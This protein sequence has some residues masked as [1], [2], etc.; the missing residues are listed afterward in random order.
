MASGYSSTIYFKNQNG[1]A[2]QYKVTIGVSEST[3][4]INI[5]NALT[6]TA[7]IQPNGSTWAGNA[8]TMEILW[9]GGV[10]GSTTLT[11][12][13]SG[14]SKTATAKFTVFHNGTT[15]KAS[16]TI[17]V[18]IHSGST[19]STAPAN[20][21]VSAGTATLTTINIT[22][23]PTSS[24]SISGITPT[25]VTAKATTAGS[26]SYIKKN[27][28]STLS[29]LITNYPD[30]PLTVLSD[31]SVWARI[32]NHDVRAGAV[33]WT[34][35]EALNTQQ[36][37]KYSRLHI[38]NDSLKDSSGKFEFFLRYPTN[39]LSAYNRWK[40]STAPQNTTI[41]RTTSGSAAPGYE[42]VNISW[43]GAYWGGLEYCS[44]GYTFL[45]GSTGHANWW[46][47][48]APYQAY[49]N[50]LPGPNPNICY[51]QTELWV[52]IPGT[53]GSTIAVTA[54]TAVTITGLQPET[55]YLFCS[56]TTN[57]AGA[58]FSTVV[59]A[60]TLT[61]QA[62]GYAYQDGSW[63]KGKIFVNQNGVWTKVKKAYGKKDGSWA[64][65]K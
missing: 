27:A 47:A 37:Y 35:S 39:S 14:Q 16:G 31:G 22:A 33:L 3:N 5:R 17:K 1:K 8:K 55:E 65:S 61:D 57:G 32:F 44:E 18:K 51:R 49:Q 52:R 43:S 13:L 19:Y 23:L 30:L 10:V 40:Q 34:S 12:L 6:I 29:Q 45:D 21:T 38:L 56:G 62:S 46:Y 60:T 11:S 36:T 15:G 20:Q 48:V 7:K 28:S 24:V 4:A 25:Q 54:N 50:G 63:K 64:Q 53:T 26:L 42:A 41:T 58:G 9:N 2:N 59:S